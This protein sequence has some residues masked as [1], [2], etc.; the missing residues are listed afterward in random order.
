MPEVKSAAD[1]S[2]KYAR[3][4]ST[5]SADYAAGIKAPRKD[6]ARSTQSAAQNYKDGVTKAAQAGSFEKGVAAAG[7]EKWQGKSIA[8]GQAR[9]APGVQAGQKDYAEAMTPVLDTISKTTLPPRYPKGDPRNYER[10]RVMGEALN[11]M[12]V[13]SK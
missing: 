5:R 6:W 12:R 11:Q 7:T 4:T 1:V 2:A 3:V 10:S 8:V 13:G 9:W